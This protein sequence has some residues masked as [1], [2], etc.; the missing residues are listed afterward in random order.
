LIT[1]YQVCSLTQA[2]YFSTIFEKQMDLSVTRTNKFR[3]I[4]EFWMKIGQF[5]KKKRSSISLKM[6][7]NCR[8]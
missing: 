3:E 1:K 8:I 6:F 2:Y 5:C 7:K 4:L